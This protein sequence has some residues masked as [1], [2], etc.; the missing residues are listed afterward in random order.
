MLLSMAAYFGLAASDE[1]ER[2]IAWLLAEQMSYG[3]WNCDRRNGATHS[4]FHTTTSS[5]EGLSQVVEIDVL[6]ARR[7]ADDGAYTK[8]LVATDFSPRAEK[9]F[10]SALQLASPGA[11]I[12]LLHCWQVAEPISTHA[13]AGGSPADVEATLE[14]RARDRA[15]ELVARHRRDGVTV[16]YRSIEAPPKI[17]ILDRAERG[18]DLIA[19]GS[20]GRR[21]PRRLLGSVAAAVTRHAPCSVLV[22]KERQS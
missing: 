13:I 1:C 3:G 7:S 16:S 11:A 9:A 22:S 14:R 18:F 5:L 21:G 2:M 10:A 17:G 6:V 19:V 8:I 20:H 12:E 15:R 4:S